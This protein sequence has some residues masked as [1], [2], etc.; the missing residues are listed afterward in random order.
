MKAISDLIK[1]LIYIAIWLFAG[2]VLY[3]IW[4][5]ISG[6][7]SAVSGAAGAVT[8]AA[9]QWTPGAITQGISDSIDQ[10]Y[11]AL[12][13]AVSNAFQPVTN[14]A[15]DI[16]DGGPSLAANNL[17]IGESGTGTAGTL[18]SDAVNEVPINDPY[19]Q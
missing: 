9:A 1:D 19:A 4:Q 11:Q 2:Y 12:I 10:D 18:I 6:V 14:I 16:Q 17:A 8:N 5:A 13:D 3:K 7:A 15:S